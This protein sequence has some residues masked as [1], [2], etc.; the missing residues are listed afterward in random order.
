M[1]EIVHYLTLR[2]SHKK[3]THLFIWKLPVLGTAVSLLPGHDE[4][5]FSQSSLPPCRT[6]FAAAAM[7]LWQWE[8][9]QKAGCYLKRI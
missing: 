2:A 9:K 7:S 3:F 6:A 4:H 1:Y 5:N 8:C